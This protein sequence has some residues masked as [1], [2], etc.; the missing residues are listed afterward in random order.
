MMKK[1]LIYPI[2][3]LILF[4][5]VGLFVIKDYGASADEHIQID[6]GHVIWRYL[7]LKMNREVPE[8]LK[9]V[10]DLHGFKNSY[11]GQAATFPTVILEAIK[12]FSLDS[13]TIIRIRH[14]WN[15]ISY[16]VGLICF[17]L[18]VTDL[19]GDPRRSALWLGLQILLPRIFG[20]IFY[21]DRDLM[22]ISWMMISLAAFCLFMRRPGIFSSLLAAFAFAVAVNT[23]I[24]G[25]V[26]LIFPFLYFVFG[27]K[28]KY[29][30]LLV[31]AALVFWFLLSPIAWDDPLHTLPEAIR[32]LSTQQRFLDT[33]N[34]NLLF[35]GKYMSE[36]DL[37]WY[38]IPMYI[39]VTTPLVTLAFCMLGIGAVLKH[40]V[41]ISRSRE[42]L[43]SAG[44]AV[45]L[46]AVPL[47]GI[48]FHLTFYN[49]WRHFYFLCLPISWLALE[50][51]LL[52][53][54][55]G[56]KILRG[57]AAVLLGVSFALSAVWIA[58]VHP[59]QI[60]YISPLF[61]EKWIGKFDRDYWILTTTE[62]MNYLL[63]NVS[64]R[65]LNVV[66]KHAFV[67]YAIIGFP[68]EDRERFH[69]IYHGAQPVP[70]EYLFFNYNQ[71]TDNEQAFDYYIPVHA[72]ERDGVKLAEIFQRS[73]NGELQPWQIVDTVSVSVNQENAAAMADSDF[74]TAWYGNDSGEIIF[75][76]HQSCILSSLEIFP[77]D[78]SAGFQDPVLSVSADGMNW[79]ELPSEPKGSNGIAFPETGTEWLKLESSAE[80]QGIQE[81]LFYGTE[82]T[83]GEENG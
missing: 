21:N 45:I 63:D 22:L 66:D 6:S 14:Y 5:A 77:A 49:G 82:S 17:A 9:D 19:T 42:T 64:E 75:H 62:C 68:P 30:L 39:V 7:C 23:R 24:F 80:H 29:I 71:K 52:V 44:M 69:M 78:G 4:L 54:N 27:E 33:G 20:D 16:F 83:G 53:W 74:H 61:R 56:S 81:V 13:S 67:E 34:A 37:P 31:P 41:R 57:A 65:T 35:F 12:G 51:V 32:H 36:A 48:V 2:L 58:R 8:A 28:R 3:I 15:F 10:P 25:L 59:Y 55:S 18:A 50:G 11:Y 79:T 43:I 70:Y 47:I 1:H 73:H 26:L 38:Y 60:L 46:I 72:I 76:F 40:G